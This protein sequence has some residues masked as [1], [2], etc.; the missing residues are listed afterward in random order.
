MAS[1][2]Y[3]ANGWMRRSNLFV[4]QA[5]TARP[6]RC[7]GE[8]WLAPGIAAV[9]APP[10]IP[11]A[12]LSRWPICLIQSSKSSSPSI[13]TSPA[14][15]TPA[16]STISATLVSWYQGRGHAPHPRRASGNS[17]E[18]QV[19]PAG[20]CGLLYVGN[21]RMV[22]DLVLVRSPYGQ[23]TS[24]YFQWKRGRQHCHGNGP[25]RALRGVTTQV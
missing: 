16:P 19:D 18:P 21:C 22:T 4:P 8:Q 20:L 2:S 15:R 14:V 1:V 9:G 5:S 7:F 11:S 25:A 23:P 17:D 24:R 12:M 13:C 3:P 6:A 10:P